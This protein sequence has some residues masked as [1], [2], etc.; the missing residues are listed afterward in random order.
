MSFRII[1]T[2][3]RDL[4]VA[5]KKYK[6]LSFNDRKQLEVMY[7]NNERP[8][9]IA[10]KLGVHTATIYKELQRGSSGNLDKN[11]RLEYSAEAAQRII[12]ENFK[13][14][15]RTLKETAPQSHQ[16]L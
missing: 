2:F 3:W 6:L 5:R 7:L 14:R 15:G 13:K 1:F 10:L 8:S 16:G 4:N 11:L 9:D 12:T